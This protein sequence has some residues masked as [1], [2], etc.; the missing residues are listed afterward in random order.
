MK[1]LWAFP[2]LSRQ[3]PHPSS[4][5]CP[6]RC[7]GRLGREAA[8]GSQVKPRSAPPP[9]RCPWVGGVLG[10]LCQPDDLCP[11]RAPSHTPKPH[12]YRSQR[13]W[14][15]GTKGFLPWCA[16]SLPAPR[17]SQW[18]WT[19]VQ[20]QKLHGLHWLRTRAPHRP[21][22]SEAIVS[23]RLRPLEGRARDH[24][25]RSCWLSCRSP[26]PPPGAFPR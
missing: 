8:P 1:A 15:A 18:V 23:L 2:L 26:P 9:D 20:W 17:W 19:G 24:S 6:S 4:V 21:C 25:S 3:S 10:P 14:E 5:L 12:R 13:A 7:H 11:V 16:D 22:D